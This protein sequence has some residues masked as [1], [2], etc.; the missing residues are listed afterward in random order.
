MAYL[1]VSAVAAAVIAIH[2]TN[3]F[4]EDRTSDL[5]SGGNL[6]PRVFRASSFSVSEKILYCLTVVAMLFTLFATGLVKLINEDAIKKRFELTETGQ[7]A[8]YCKLILMGWD[9]SVSSRAEAD[10]FAGLLAETSLEMLVETASLGAQKRKTRLDLT[11]LFLRRAAGFVIYAAMQ[12]SSYAAIVYLTVQSSQIQ[13]LAGD[14]GYIAFLAPSIVPAAVS[15]IN[16]CTPY[17]VR[18]ITSFECWESG[19]VEVNMLIVRMWLSRILN[20]AILGLTYS[21][22]ADPY[23]MADKDSAKL[24][25]RIEVSF[26]NQYPCRLDQAGAGVV[27]LIITDLVTQLV[28]LVG[29]NA[30]QKLQAQIFREPWEKEEFDTAESMVGILYNAGLFVLILPYS[31][32]SLLFAPVVLAIIFK[33]RTWVLFKYQ[34]KPKRPWSFQAAGKTFTIFYL[35][36]TVAT[37]VLS[38]FFFLSNTNLPKLCSIQDANVGLCIDAVD[39]V[40]ETCNLDSSSTFFGIFSDKSLCEGGYPYCVCH[41]QLACGPFIKDNSAIEILQQKISVVPFIGFLYAYFVETSYG[42]WI[43][44]TVL[45]ILSRF[46]YAS[47]KVAKTTKIERETQYIAQVS[48]LQAEKKRQAKAINRLRILSIGEAHDSFADAEKV[49]HFEN[50]KQSAY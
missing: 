33:S 40:S 32:V 29:V 9:N 26:S 43:L 39:L 44:V 30:L 12:T 49:T 15:A 20:I 36:T 22:L 38:T 25:R 50:Q 34:I 1:L 31:P 47:Y 4:R 13:T 14:V 3:I 5:F 21:L 10:R 27:S 35:I 45:A 18:I 19:Q 24:R 23:L 6:F 2:V 11:L 37:G 17:I 48:S 46:R 16:A 41:G 7:D 28:F 42:A 8:S